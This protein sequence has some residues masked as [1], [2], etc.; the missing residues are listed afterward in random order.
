M[1]KTYKYRLFPTAAQRT[2]LQQQL[3]ARRRVYNR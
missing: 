3:D 1:R 2:A